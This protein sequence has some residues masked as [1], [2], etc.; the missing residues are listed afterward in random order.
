[1]ALGENHVTNTNVSGTDAVLQQTICSQVEK[2]AHRAPMT[3]LMLI[4]INIYK[5]ENHQ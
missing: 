2:E 5:I 3:I 4:F 1:M